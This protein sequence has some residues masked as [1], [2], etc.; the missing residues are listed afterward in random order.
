[1]IS[2]VRVSA[3]CKIAC[4]PLLT[5]CVSVLPFGLPCLFAEARR[6]E[7]PASRSVTSEPPGSFVGSI[8]EGR[9]PCPFL[10]TPMPRDFLTYRSVNATSSELKTG[11]SRYRMIVYAA[12]GEHIMG[13]GRSELPK[14]DRSVA[15]SSFQIVSI[16]KRSQSVGGLIDPDQRFS[17]FDM[18]ER[19]RRGVGR[20]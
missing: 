11:F 14:L 12:R 13:P 10:A 17:G 2:S 1:M 20:N 15:A 3:A 8:S 16:P 19:C 9:E 18:Y 7:R 6:L 5:C 4:R